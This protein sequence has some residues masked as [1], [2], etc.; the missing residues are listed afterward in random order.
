MILRRPHHLLLCRS[1]ERINYYNIILRI[2][3]A[4]VSVRL[5]NV[6]LENTHASDPVQFERDFWEKRAAGI[7][8]FVNTV[9][10]QLSTFI[11]LI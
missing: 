6:R 9:R 11:I 1:H 5:K 7:Y 2:A 10:G 4:P 3:I 8:P